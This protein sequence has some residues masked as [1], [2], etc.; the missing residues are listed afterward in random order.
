MSQTKAIY[1]LLC[2][3]PDGITAL[4]ALNECGSLRLAARISDLRASGHIIDTKLET[5]PNGKRV[6]RYFLVKRPLWR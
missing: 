1:R 4:E 6:A 5:Q 3:R 2:D